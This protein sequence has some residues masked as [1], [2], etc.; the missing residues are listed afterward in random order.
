M[1]KVVLGGDVASCNNLKFDITI[2]NSLFLFNLET[3]ITKEWNRPSRKAGPCLFAE[4]LALPTMSSESRI[5]GNMANNHIMDYGEIGLNETVGACRSGG[6]ETVGAG[7]NLESALQPVVRNLKG[8]SIG[9]IA[10]TETQFGVAT[11]WRAGVAPIIPG[12]TA[13]LVNKLSKQVDIAVVS[14]HVAAEMCPWPS[15]QWQD[16]LRGFI[17]AG[18]SIVHGHHS[19]VPQGYERYGDGL[20][21]YG[22]GNF[23][24]EPLN[25]REQANTL[26]SLAC[27][28]VVSKNRLNEFNVRTVVIEDSD[29]ITVRQSNP[30]EAAGHE[31]Y[32]EH[33][34]RPL[35][36]RALLTRI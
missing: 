19:H 5:V 15:P 6:F 34:N 26:W 12:K 18:A 28:I 13:I 9:I 23:C 17:D 29:P 21:F 16:L 8:L 20:I 33:A 4:E 36:D 25:W 35:S 30:E 7:L 22:L 2:E 14:V 10:C 31:R 24:V 32:L 27:D 11:P 3:P 1:T